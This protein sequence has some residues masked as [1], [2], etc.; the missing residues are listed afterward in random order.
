MML[1]SK[2][3]IS[4][5]SGLR[6]TSMHKRREV[7]ALLPHSLPCPKEQQVKTTGISCI[8]SEYMCTGL[9]CLLQAGAPGPR[10][11]KKDQTWN[12]L[13]RQQGKVLGSLKVQRALQVTPLVRTQPLC[14]PSSSSIKQGQGHP[15]GEVCDYS[16]QCYG[17]VHTGPGN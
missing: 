7:T 12:K 3:F 9:V 16:H 13:S 14:A 17:K 10:V 4:A 15:P 8:V 6:Q 2:L 5:G 1:F 11:P